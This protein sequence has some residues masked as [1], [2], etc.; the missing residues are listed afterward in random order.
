MRLMTYLSWNA[1]FVLFAVVCALLIDEVPGL[2]VLWLWLI[3]VDMGMTVFL[4]VRFGR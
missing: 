3:I 2:A 1:I 4:F